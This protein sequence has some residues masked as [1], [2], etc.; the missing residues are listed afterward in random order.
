MGQWR[1]CQSVKRNPLIKRSIT[2]IEDGFALTASVHDTWQLQWWILSQGARIV[3]QSPSELRQS[4]QQ[5]VE[6]MYQN[7]Q[8]R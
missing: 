2:A 1:S 4:I 3:I 8:L 7:Y 6:Q 5:Q